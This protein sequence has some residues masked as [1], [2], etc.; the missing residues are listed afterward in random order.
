MKKTMI[1]VS[2]I[3]SASLGF[4]SSAVFFENNMGNPRNGKIILVTPV[5]TPLLLVNNLDNTLVVMN[6]D[7]ENIVYYGDWTCGV[8]TGQKIMPLEKMTIQGAHPGFTMYVCT[9]NGSAEVRLV[10]YP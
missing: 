5:P 8:S 10:E 3:L 1:V 7:A 2:A 9:A 4:C 6:D